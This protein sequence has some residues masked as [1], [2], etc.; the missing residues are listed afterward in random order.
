MPTSP[1]VVFKTDAELKAILNE[2]NRNSL[3][4]EPT[5]LKHVSFSTVA[6]TKDLMSKVSNKQE[7]KGLQKLGTDFKKV[8]QNL[9]S[10]ED[11]LQMAS[12][13]LNPELNKEVKK[14]CSELSRDLTNNY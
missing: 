4:S 9:H 8:R 14:Q 2:T 10:L 12:S 11:I 6:E 3:R 5:I 1:P 7:S 13:Y